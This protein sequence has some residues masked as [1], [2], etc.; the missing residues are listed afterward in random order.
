[1]VVVVVVVVVVGIGM[2]AVVIEVVCSRN[3][4]GSSSYKGGI[5][6]GYMVSVIST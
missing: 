1:M 2:V 6:S 4:N 5:F 3:M